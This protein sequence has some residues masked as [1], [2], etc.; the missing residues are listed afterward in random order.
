LL[1]GEQP[2]ARRAALDADQDWR[3]RLIGTIPDA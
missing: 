3:R 1:F 2:E